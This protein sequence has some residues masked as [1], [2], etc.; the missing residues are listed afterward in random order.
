MK[1]SKGKDLTYR[2]KS[3]RLRKKRACHAMKNNLDELEQAS[4][5]CIEVLTIKL[6]NGNLILI[7]CSIKKPKR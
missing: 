3:I 1:K 6:I 2:K 5:L 4:E 7:S